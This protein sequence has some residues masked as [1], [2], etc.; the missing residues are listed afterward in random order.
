MDNLK[1]CESDYR[2][3]KLVWENEPIHS[4]KLVELC[5]EQ[6]DW[7]KS[8]TYTMIKKLS[9][10]GFAKSENAIVTSIIKKEEVQAYESME[11]K[12]KLVDNYLFHN[13]KE[14]SLEEL[15]KL[16]AV[17][18][19]ALKNV[20]YAYLIY[21]TDMGRI[22]TRGKLPFDGIGNSS[23][24][25]DLMAFSSLLNNELDMKSAS[26]WLR[27]KGSVV[28]VHRLSFPSACGIFLDQGLN[29]C[30]LHWQADS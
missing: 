28:V 26:V 30:P 4:S 2:F 25:S 14:A 16:I 5:N 7:K 9:E 24:I 1:L 21:H 6:F 19:N 3:M 20:P 22:Y 18:L 12:K 29:L 11:W 23:F 10:K 8:T 15:A 17:Y 27:L 13:M